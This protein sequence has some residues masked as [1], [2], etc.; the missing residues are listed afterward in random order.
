F[1]LPAY[2]ASEKLIWLIAQAPLRYSTRRCIIG[3]LDQTFPSAA[4]LGSSQ[5]RHEL[6]GLLPVILDHVSTT[7]DPYNDGNTVSAAIREAG[8]RGPPMSLELAGRLVSSSLPN[9]PQH[10]IAIFEAIGTPEA[11][12]RLLAFHWLSQEWHMK[13]SIESAIESLAAKLGLVIARDVDGL[14]IS[15]SPDPSTA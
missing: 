2:S 4:Q 15:S 7:P 3:G 1:L 8:R 12:R 11:L 6:R 14:V 13:S 10:G 9:V 5:A